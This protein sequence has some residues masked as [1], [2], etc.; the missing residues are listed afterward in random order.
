MNHGGDIY[1]NKVEMDYSVSLNPMGTPQEVKDAILGSMDSIGNYPDPLQEDVRDAI[2][3][4]IGLHRDC[5]YAGSGASE[6]LMAAAQ[7]IQPKK[8]FL[9]EPSYT[10]YAH[11]LRSV[12]CEAAHHVLKEEDGFRIGDQAKDTIPWDADL[13]IL[14][15]PGNP[16][17][18]NIEEEI[19]C[20]I[21]NKAKEIGAAVILDESFLAL[22]EKQRQGGF[23]GWEDLYVI[24]S[25]TKLFAMPGIRAGYVTTS[26][27]N[28]EMLRAF[29]PEWNLSIP[30]GAAIKAGMK[31]IRDTDFLPRTHELIRKERE[32][33]KDGLSE[34]G[35]KVFKSESPYLL[36]KGPEELYE[37]LLSK[38]VL[39]REC[40]D[41]AGL[42]K[43]FYR[44][45]V[46][47]HT[48]NEKLIRILKEIIH[49]I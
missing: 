45:A 21:I 11:V 30:S 4:A 25:L 1:R 20:G 40:S 3:G 23:E 18:V 37:K 24:T 39:I 43:G 35:L 44:I 33:L 47:D 6:L 10:G 41:M 26:P 49:E 34:A 19:L 22:S 32:Y 42:E 15:D 9:F 7:V 48:E 27:S 28:I 31:V 13:I 36:F 5:I 12:G 14:C 46:K 17:G 38:A 16:T 8:A 2:S 29:L